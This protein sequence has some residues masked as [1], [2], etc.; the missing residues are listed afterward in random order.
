[1]QPELVQQ[2]ID[3]VLSGAV[4]ACRF[5]K[6]AVQRH[7]DDLEHGWERGLFFDEDAGAH[8]VD[9]F[10]FLR[11]SK[12]DL[13]GEEFILEPWEQFIVW[14]L[15][16]WMREA[17]PDE[18]YVRRRFSYGYIEV[19]RKNGKSTLLAGIGLY[20]LFAD[21]E[22]GA[23]IYTA[24]VD[25]EQARIIHSESIRMVESSPALRKRIGV[26]KDNLHVTAT[27]SRYMPLS[28]EHKAKHGL[29]IHGGLVDELHVH[30]N[31]HMWDVL[32]TGTSSRR[33]PL[34]LAI[35]TAGYDRFSICWEQRDYV[36]RILRGVIQDDGYFG[37][38]FTLDMRYDWPELAERKDDGEEAEGQ[39]YEDDWKDEANW[40]KANPNLGVSKRRSYMAQERAFALESPGYQ[41]THQQLDLNIWTQSV[42]RWL[43]KARWDDC[44]L[45]VLEKALAGRACYGGLDLS[46]S[47]DITALLLVFPPEATERRYQ[48]LCRFWIPKDNMRARVD[49]DKV[50]YD[51]WE[52]AGLITA[53]EG[54][55][56]DY[57]FILDQVKKDFKTFDIRELAFD[58]WGASKLMADLQEI[59]GEDWLVQF[60]QGFASMSAPA[61]ELERMV[62]AGELAHGGNPV[63]G[64][65][66]DNVVIKRDPAGNIKP[67]K[68]KSI[69]KIDGIVALIMAIDRAIKNG[70]TGPSVYEQRGFFEL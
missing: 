27:A 63:L 70:G 52:K 54:N 32:K 44:A 57:A 19:A 17:T 51:V 11:H 1:V 9:F 58:R 41:N 30:P 59:G 14:S 49:R 13:G 18:P 29:N 35:T 56:V 22:P 64:W 37:I 62:L 15:F 20:L 8:A 42:K 45:P 55:V 28:A 48:V 3:D 50:P 61:K 16:G 66:A 46:S 21:G 67:D 23:E 10:G 69:E 4:V 7:V 5:V 68:E 39:Q 12:G 43:S 36:A 6:L 60:G 24:A 47:I 33:Q 40:P 2:Y 26:Y 25:K 34:I 53:T 65:M 38:I 31:R